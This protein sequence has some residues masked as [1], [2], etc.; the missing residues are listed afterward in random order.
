M[1]KMQEKSNAKINAASKHARGVAGDYPE[2]ELEL[3]PEAEQE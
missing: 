3:L 2:S 1:D